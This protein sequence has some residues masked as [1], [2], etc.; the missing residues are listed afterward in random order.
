MCGHF[1]LLDVWSLGVILFMLIVGHSPFASGGA[2]ETLAH[3]M[4]GKYALPVTVSE[5]CKR[6]VGSFL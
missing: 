4:D 3:I 2:N 5:C 1:A 6:C